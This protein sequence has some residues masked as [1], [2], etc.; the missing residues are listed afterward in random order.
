MRI[1]S[2]CA[3]VAPYLFVQLWRASPRGQKSNIE[4]KRARHT[5][6][7]RNEL[8]LDVVTLPEVEFKKSGFELSHREVSIMQLALR[9]VAQR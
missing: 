8:S 1:S 4:L 6:R 7:L 5:L 3:C 9:P 2:H